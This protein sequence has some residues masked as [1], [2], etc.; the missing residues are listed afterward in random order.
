MSR[1]RMNRFLVP[2]LLVLAAGTP[3]L[4]QSER[5][6]RGSYDRP[7][8]RDSQ[9]LSRSS[10][11]VT[12]TNSDGQ[13]THSIKIQNG[14]ITAEI[15]GKAVP[16]ERIQR[17]GN[18]VRLMG[19]DGAVLAEFNVGQ[20]GGNPFA[21]MV[22]VPAPAVGGGGGGGS[23]PFAP[24]ATVPA[25]PTPPEMPAGAM[26]WTPPPVMI[27]ITMSSLD[28]AL[29]EHLELNPEEVILVDRIIDGLPASK[30]GLKTKD[31][32]VEIE[33]RKPATQPA[34][35]EILGTKKP[36]DS[37]RLLVI[38]RGKPEEL[39]LTLEPYQ[40][41]KLEIRVQPGEPGMPPAMVDVPGERFMLRIPDGMRNLED[42]PELEA[43][44]REQ[45]EEALRGLRDLKPDARQFDD[46]RR[47]VERALADALEA[48]KSR[49]N[50]TWRGLR[51][52]YPRAASPLAPRPEESE[53]L[54]RSLEKLTARLESLSERLEQLERRLDKIPATPR[55]GG[56]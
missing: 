41:E 35:R 37:L 14:E 31:I 43:K 40:A 6:P 11:V 32:I 26:V 16:R 42:N 18:R 21:P 28:P 34:L 56:R 39:R 20:T 46:V 8:V 15:N 38:R 30:G 52:V 51:D 24:M 29:A 3:A 4:A 2:A 9:P 50:S 19:E 55:E 23:K 27:G 12:M 13:N 36:G 47:E 1:P 53:A 45:I 33:G 22:T 5:E 25:P 17:R 10:S 49:P 54:A 44:V 48:S 7:L